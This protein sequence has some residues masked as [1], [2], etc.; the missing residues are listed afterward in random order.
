MNNKLIPAFLLVILFYT[1]AP[2]FAEN[3]GSLE[4]LKAES[5]AT[6]D[7]N[8]ETPRNPIPAQSATATAALTTGS[9]SPSNSSK[10]PPAPNR[11]KQAQGAQGQ[12]IGSGIGALLGAIGFFVSVMIAAPSL[13]DAAVKSG[14]PAP[15][16]L[17]TLLAVMLS[18]F[19]IMRAK[20]PERLLGAAG[21]AIGESMGRRKDNQEFKT[22][23]T[24]KMDDW[25][26]DPPKKVE[27][28]KSP[29]EAADET[30]A[31]ERFKL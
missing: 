27:K 22:Y 26:K 3:G 2:G 21:R 17:A 18:A 10:S 1:H 30:S 4:K 23:L 5:G 25:L 8:A 13:Y 14:F 19:L 7:Q 20:L 11:N 6:F 9:E 15:V 31:E 16:A 24:E 29:V 12:E 28:E